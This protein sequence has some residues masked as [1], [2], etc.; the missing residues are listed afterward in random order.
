MP[1]NCNLED[2]KHIKK[3]VDIPVVCAGKMQL[4]EGAKAVEANEL[5]GV[6][7]ARQFLAD[8]E[9]VTKVMNDKEDDIRPCIHCH[10]ACFNMSH[11][12]G[13]ANDQA[14]SDNAGM[15]RCAVNPQTMQSKKYQIKK[16]SSSK[17]VAIIGGGIGGMEAARVLALRGHKPT[18]FE[19]TNELG[20]IFIA[21]AALS[22]KEAD[23][24]LIAWF[25]KQIADL[26]VEVK[27]NTEVKSMDELAGY[28]KVIVATGSKP[29]NL[30]IKGK[31][32]AIEACEYL[33]NTK[34]VGKK[35][36]IVGGG[37]TGCE[38]AYDLYQKGHTPVIVEMKNDLI[39]VRGVCLANTSYLRDF[40]ALNN[41]EVHLETA[42]KEIKENGIIAKDKD[43]KEFAIEADSTIISVGYVPTPALAKSSKVYLV[44]DCKSVG[45]LR[46]V[47]WRAWDIAMKI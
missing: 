7:F 24:Q 1:N 12:K 21:A 27:F 15:A 47:I 34:E 4:D 37:L 43:G 13:V 6:G 25:K 42:V 41:V 10:N 32:N 5:D 17:N 33:L 14:L 23:K 44:G 29:R 20:G 38:I 11:Y 8:P 35:V 2:V 36:V 31:D 22:F 30:P 19:K 45:N 39:A 46:T 28:D 26:N 18:I 9:W 40:F 3:F 16:A